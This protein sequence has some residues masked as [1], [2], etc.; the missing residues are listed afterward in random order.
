MSLLVASVFYGGDK[1]ASETKNR[2]WLTLQ[3]RFLR[4]TTKNYDYAVFLN[5]VSNPENFDHLKVIGS[6]NAGVVEAPCLNHL[7]GLQQIVEYCRS[8][9]YDRYLILD[10]DAFPINAEWQDIDCDLA[11]VVRYENLDLFPHPSAMFFSHKVL[12]DMN[13]ISVDELPSEKA[14]M[15]AEGVHKDPTL[16]IPFYPLVRSNVWNPHPVMAGVY[17]D[18]FFHMGAGSRFPVLRAS[19]RKYHRQYLDDRAICKAIYNELKEDAEG[20]INKLRFG[21]DA[22]QEPNISIKNLLFQ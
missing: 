8:N 14:F 4:K 12:D 7:Y 2:L 13:F 17:H 21:F 1:T 10:S 19:L 11:A 9:K 22:L 5:S 15:W 6:L 20:Y 3:E 18:M 16:D